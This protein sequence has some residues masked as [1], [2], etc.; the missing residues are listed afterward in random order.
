MPTPLPLESLACVNPECPTY[1]QPA[2]GNLILRKTYGLQSTRY[3]RCRHCQREFCERK[4]TALWNAKIPPEQFVSA[5][6]HLTEGTSISATVRLTK[7]HHDTVERI[8]LVCG[9]HAKM[10]H[11]HTAKALSVTALQADERHGFVQNKATP[12]WEATVLDPKSKFI[13]ALSLGRRDEDLILDLLQDARRR[14]ADP[15]SLVLFTDGLPSYAT[16]FP[17]VFGV[18]FRPP[19]KHLQGR[20][21]AVRYRIP[22]SLAHTQVIKH[23][24]GHRLVKVEVRLAH[25]S[26]R[27]VDRELEA[28][29]YTVANTSAIERQNGTAR[30]MT[31]HMHRKGLSFARRAVTRS[32]SAYLVTLC[33]N[34]CRVNASLKRVLPEPQGKRRYEH[35][36]PAMAI[37]IAERLFTLGELLATPLYPNPAGS[38]H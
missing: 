15:Q 8:A 38:S 5:A 24:Q 16:L 22:R 31:P 28:L 32:A 12:C 36:T 35:R 27:R 37:G 18:A 30:Q 14:I 17:R 19:R 20:A 11:D 3:L 13:V 26:Q 34:G 10:L 33:Y 21:P 4:G 2:K 29:G 7:L 23:R 25:G 6:E 9:P 1:G